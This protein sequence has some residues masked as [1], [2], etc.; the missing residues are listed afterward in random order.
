MLFFSRTP[1]VLHS[2]QRTVHRN[3]GQASHASEQEKKNTKT[4]VVDLDG[5]GNQSVSFSCASPVKKFS[6]SPVVYPQKA[7]ISPPP[8]LFSSQNEASV[9]PAIPVCAF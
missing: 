1:L 8:P 2:F 5:A 9:A 7:H 3:R 4:D 6:L